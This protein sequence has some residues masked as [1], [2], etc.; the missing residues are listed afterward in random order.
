VLVWREVVSDRAV[1][2]CKAT[3]AVVFRIRR[4]N[5]NRTHPLPSRNPA[6]LVSRSIDHP[7]QAA[8]GHSGVAPRFICSRSRERDCCYRPD[9]N[10]AEDSPHWNGRTP[11]HWACYKGDLGVVRYLLTSRGAIM[12][13]AT[14]NGGKTPLLLACYQG[15]LAVVQELVACGANLEATD[16]G[17][18][19]P[20]HLACLHCHLALVQAIGDDGRS[21]LRWACHGGNMAIVGL[22][23]DSNRDSLFV[24]NEEGNTPLD[25]AKLTGHH[26][27]VN[28]LLDRYEETVFERQDS[29]SIHSILRGATYSN[30]GNGELQA[31]LPIG[32]LTETQL[33][34]LL[35]SLLA[36]LSSAAQILQTVDDAS[37]GG[38]PLHISCETG[39]PVSVVRLLVESDMAPV[40]IV[41]LSTGALPIHAACGAGAAFE[42]IQL[43]V[44]RGGAT[45]LRLRDVNGALPIHSACGT[46]TSLEVIE[47]LIESGGAGTLWEQDVNGALPI[48]GACGAG[49]SVGGI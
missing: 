38:T 18:S 32:E 6:T 14:D 13:E 20:L 37:G 8:S 46:G 31:L 26:D 27:C 45:T 12:L 39:A 34:N 28:Y 16:N 24:Q 2:Q 4:R 44:D 36:R 40:F 3:R 7:K 49:V 42:V 1:V 9:K 23:V 30:N 25:A 47:L 41:K 35:R 29:V 22:L 43:L 21:S 33:L 15:R 48:H 10:M 19:T 5:D 17:G 11:L